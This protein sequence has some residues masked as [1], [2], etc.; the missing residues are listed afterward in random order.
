[1]P[2]G[3]MRAVVDTV[4][5][6][7]ASAVRTLLDSRHRRCRCVR[8]WRLRPRSSSTCVDVAARKLAALRCHRTQLAGDALD[9][10]SDDEARR[11]LGVEHFRRAEVGSKDD[12]FIERLAASARI[13]GAA[14][15][16]PW[17][18][19]PVPTLMRETLL[20]LLRCPFCGGRLTLVD[21]EALVRTHGRIESGVLGCD[22]CAFPVVAGIPV[23]IAD[24]TTREAMHQM[25][26]GSARTGAVHTARPRRS[27]R[28]CVP[29][30][31]A[32]RRRD[33]SRRAGDPEP[34]RRGGLLPVPLLGPDVPDD[35]GAA[36]G[37][38]P[39]RRPGPAPV[40]DLCGGS[41]HLTRV[42]AGLEPAGGVINADM[43]FWKLWMARR[44]TSP[45]CDAIC[46]DANNPL[47]FARDTCS[48]VVLADAFP[49][50]WHKR[51]LAEEMMRAGRAR[52]GHRAAAPAQLARREFL[53]GHDAYAG[54]LREP[55]GAVCSHVFSA[56]SVSSTV[57]S[58]QRTVDL[59]RS[60]SPAEIGDRAV[61]DPR[62]QQT[63]GSVST[64]TMSEIRARYEE[65]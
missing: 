59:T 18:L 60:A 14:F 41:G 42:L 45:T 11:L 27:A 44:F 55:A 40:L 28:R 53:G 47:P 6:R 31:A 12:A 49:Y 51:L 19:K 38:R 32:A 54:R 4:A 22:C 61:I 20:D 1:M 62:R 29:G 15:R 64:G 7:A 37:V 10:L 35:R 5:A 46:C 34:R 9:L 25:E 24:D 13:V 56:T 8:R 3:G 16:R 57:C 63:R 30:A 48:L 39:E 50:I 17:R 58:N 26:A 65:S 33:L 2:P 43:Y 23:L 36:A 21:N 52:R